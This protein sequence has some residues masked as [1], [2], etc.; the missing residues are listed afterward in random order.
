[1]VRRKNAEDE[2]QS[3]PFVPVSGTP[4]YRIDDVRVPFG[5]CPLQSIDMNIPSPLRW[6]NSYAKCPPQNSFHSIFQHSPV[7]A[8]RCDRDGI[9]VETNSALDQL[10]GLDLL[11]QR[12]LRFFDLVSDNERSAT[13]EL[14]RGLISGARESIRVQGKNAGHA[15]AVTS[16]TA[17]RQ[18]GSVEELAEVFLIG[19]SGSESGATHES[20]LQ[21]QRWEAVGRL[22]GGV[23]H[24]FN[25][26]LT[27]VMLNCDLLLSS[28][29]PI[30]RRRRHADEIRSA[31]LQATGLVQQLLG[32]ARPKSGRMRPLY[33][34]QVIEGMRNLLTRLIGANIALDF[35]LDSDLGPVRI[36][37]TQAQQI[38]L[39]LVLNARDALPRGGRIVVETSNCKFQT[40]AGSHLAQHGA[41]AFPCVLLTV[42]DNGQGMDAKTLERLFE[43]FFTT[44]SPG[45]GTGLGLTTVRSIV[46]ANR[47]LIH[48]ESEPRVGTRVMILLPRALESADAV[49]LDAAKSASDPSPLPLSSSPFQEVKEEQVL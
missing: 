39:N 40:V 41:A 18:P 23:V 35:C 29:D 24:D 30:D 14:F 49:F 20:L 7:A 17:W 3:S 26:L 34:N 5:T 12:P 32:F 4:R 22:A 43:P 1:M 31:I 37:Q 46:T 38:L 25:N 44:K 47:G 9:I 19:Q 42:S 13:V 15:S 33:F 36:D 27:G 11:S 48:V 21:T 28:L 6:P 10:L 16:W 8:G 45:R 2:V